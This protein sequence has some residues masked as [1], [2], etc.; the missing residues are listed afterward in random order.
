MAKAKTKR[1]P[2]RG[3]TDPSACNYNR[4]ATINDGT[5]I[6]PGCFDFFACNF[7]PNS[8][9][10]DQSLCEGYYGCTDPIASNYDPNA[11]CDDG[12]CIS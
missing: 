2:R 3:C 8:P 12:S 4:R 10:H 7:D 1:E 5:C 9:C 6:Y 11:S